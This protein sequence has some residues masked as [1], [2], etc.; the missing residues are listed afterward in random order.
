M[1]RNNQE[2]AG[3]SARNDDPPVSEVASG[4]NSPLTFT[5]PTEFVELP[6]GGRFYPEDHPLHGKETIEIRFMTAKDEDIL[7]SKALLKKGLAIDRLLENII[8]DKRV[9]TNSLFVGDKNAIIIAARI[10]GYGEN[11]VTQVTC[12]ICAT[13]EEYPFNLNDKDIVGDDPSTLEEYG[14][15][16]NDTGTYTLKLPRTGVEVEVRLLTGADEKK[17]SATADKRRKHKLPES[18]MTEQFKSFIISVNGHTD[19]NS[20]HSFIE[21]MPASDSRH[22]RTAYKAITPNVDLT[23]EWACIACGYDTE[24]EVPF[25][26][27]FFWPKR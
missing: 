11:Y 24:M 3:S 12:P 21:N 13:T 17:L 15:Q 22:L 1:A 16:Q 23:Q 26:P 2:R 7:T 6:T 25:T 5:T 14:A 8:V 10:T 20:I 18:P 9:K 27:E 4:G 19:M